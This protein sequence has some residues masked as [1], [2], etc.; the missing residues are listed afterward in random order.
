M[1][2]QNRAEG[3]WQGPLVF[4]VIIAAAIVFLIP[5]LSNIQLPWWLEW[6]MNPRA[7][8]T[9]WSTVQPTIVVTL[10]TSKDTTILSTST[11]SAQ[12]GFNIRPYRY[13]V[14]YSDGSQDTVP[15]NW[16]WLKIPGVD[17]GGMLAVS[18]RD[19]QFQFYGSL[20]VNGVEQ[21]STIEV[22][23]SITVTGEGKHIA[24]DSGT[25]SFISGQTPI[26]DS[27]LSISHTDFRAKL[28]EGYHTVVY[29]C[30]ATAY[31]SFGGERIQSQW[32]REMAMD[33]VISS[34][35]MTV[36]VG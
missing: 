12:G 10:T 7:G 1:K 2:R 32:T 27:P 3:S 28:G 19:L 22:V 18:L 23:Y 29:R 25:L 9:V 35:G 30:S 33:L 34:E 16:P 6:W 15:F 13:T 26:T 24:E 11:Q 14:V 21:P 36:A 5:M 17:G 20:Q 31:F 8:G 4:V